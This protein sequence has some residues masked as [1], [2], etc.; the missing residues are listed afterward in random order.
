MASKVLVLPEL[1]GLV[2]QQ[3]EDS[4]GRSSLARCLRVNKTW[5]TEAVRILWRRCGGYK[6]SGGILRRP[7]INCLDALAPGTLDPA[8]LKMAY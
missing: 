8:Y 5:F 1:L 4:S 6:L 7:S 2:L 3:L